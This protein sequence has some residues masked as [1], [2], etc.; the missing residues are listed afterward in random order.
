[1]KHIKYVPGKEKDLFYI[2]ERQRGE[3]E[4]CHGEGF[5]LFSSGH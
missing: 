3:I 2:F 1:M 4:S 5:A